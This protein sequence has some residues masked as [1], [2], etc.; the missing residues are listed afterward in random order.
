[1]TEV[2]TPE[3][4]LMEVTPVVEEPKNNYPSNV[5][6]I[7]KEF[8]LEVGLLMNFADITDENGPILTVNKRG[9]LMEVNCYFKAPV[10]P[11]P[12]IPVTEEEKVAVREKKKE[13]RRDRRGMNKDRKRDM[14]R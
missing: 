3:V 14:A 4:P 13:D 11:E 1:M 2:A 12:E 8:L 9:M 6:P 5:A 7:K 10:V